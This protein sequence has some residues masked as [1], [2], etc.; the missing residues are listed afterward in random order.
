MRLIKQKQNLEP[1][2]SQTAER[3]FFS[4][5][6]KP[7][8]MSLLATI[9]IL[10]VSIAQTSGLNNAEISAGMT[11]S[12]RDV[13]LESAVALI[14][15]N[16]GLKPQIHMPL[17]EK[18]SLDIQ[19]ASL[20]QA[21]V[22]A[23]GNMPIDWMVENKN[24]H[25][26]KPRET[27]SRFSD[28]GQAGA[29][30]IGGAPVKQAEPSVSRIVPL[31]KRRAEDVQKLLKDLNQS[32]SVV[33]DS[34]TNSIILLGA[35]SQVNEAEALCQNLDEMPVTERQVASAPQLIQR[36]P[37]VTEVFELEHAD[38]E[39]V[40]KELGTVIVRQESGNSTTSNTTTMLRDKDG[41]P[42]ETEYFVIDKARRI[43]LI[44]TTEEKFGV[45]KKY[46]DSINKPLAQVLI[47]TQIVAIDSDFERDLGIKWNTDV[48]YRG[49]GNPWST[50]GNQVPV[51]P[52]DAILPGP[53]AFQFGKWNLTSLQAVLNTAE[54]N[55]KA[56]VLSR[57]RIMALTG[58][59]ASIH[60]GTELP[61][62]TSTTVTEGGNITQNVE[63]KQIGVKLDVTPT[64]HT[65][66]KTIRLHLT[67]EVS[68]SIGLAPNGAPIISTR[69]S[70]TTV[71]LKDGETMVIGGLIS[72]EDSKSG[73]GVPMLRDIPVIGRLFQFS[74]KTRKK[75]NL[76]I[77][78]TT[79]MVNE[80]SDLAVKPE[81]VK[82]ISRMH[83]TTT[84]TEAEP[85]LAGIT[86]VISQ[87]SPAVKV[88]E[89]PEVAADKEEPADVRV[90]KLLQAYQK[91]KK[92]IQS[93]KQ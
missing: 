91:S 53:Q 55:N 65:N 90:K 25:V 7:L 54:T 72:S 50:G 48:G 77:L 83:G 80:E 81:A 44:H 49:P 5:L 63:F 78:L 71:E 79:R 82:S 46:F 75:T 40:E 87:D 36:Q 64:I 61:Y 74:K 29:Q 45:I 14:A 32:I 11:L 23:L 26:F 13:P 2:S 33:F 4:S 52:A 10:P 20:D 21:M 68:D 43:V 24:L 6:G 51:A 60:I 9:L 62:T 73:G 37:Y 41:K 58:R 84:V 39:E 27:W 69:R 88:E 56:Q 59:P 16:F 19:N 70:E 93:D 35:E 86:D 38:M 85:A 67:P 30:G 22:K 34:P 1:A 28:M 66:N 18:V 8:A 57:P 42:I 3:S 31:G 92:T 76:I 15:E 12:V 47:E 89:K 17:A